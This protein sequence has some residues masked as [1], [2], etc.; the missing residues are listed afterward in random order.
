MALLVPEIVALYQNL[1]LKKEFFQVD[2]AELYQV[3]NG[4]EVLVGMFDEKLE[5]FVRVDK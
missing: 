2:G 4:K 1:N 5:R 3:T